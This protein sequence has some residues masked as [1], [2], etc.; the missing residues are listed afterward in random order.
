MARQGSYLTIASL[1]LV[2]AGTRADAQVG[3]E[4][5]ATFVTRDK[6]GSKSDTIQQTTKGKNVRMDGMNRSGKSGGGGMIIDGD[7]K[8]FIIVDDADKTAMIMSQA[9]QEKMRAMTEGMTANMPKRP[10]ARPTAT[11]RGMEIAKTGRTE[12][13]AGVR[14]EVYHGVS[15]DKADKNEGEICVADGVGFGMFSAIASNPMFQQ[16]GNKQFDQFR[17]ILGDG[18]GVIKATSI[19]NGKSY[20]SLELI[21]LDK[22]KIADSA[23]EPPVGYQV[24][25]MGDMMQGVTDAMDKMK[26]ARGGKPPQ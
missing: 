7:K 15:T 12:T 18:K 5:V 3:F 9:D 16:S 8:R 1:A 25:S 22:K 10:T 21:K 6:Q 11:E 4:G 19:E 17:K 24:R 23:F 2:V 13:V 20:V 14:C 26:K